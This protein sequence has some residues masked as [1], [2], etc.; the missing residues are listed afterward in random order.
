MK[1]SLFYLF[2]LICSVSLFTS[3]KDD[4]EYVHP[5]S[6]TYTFA[7]YTVTDYPWD[8][9][10]VKK[11]WPIAG[12]LHINW[13][14]KDDP[15]VNLYATLIRYLGGTI[16][17]QVLGSINLENDGNIVADYVA[18]PNV[19]MD[20]SKIMGIMLFGN[21]FPSLDEVKAGFATGGFITSPKGIATW[22]ENGGKFTVKLNIQA[23]L[24]SVTGS[25]ASSLGDI[26]NT[27]LDS[28]P[29]TIKGLLSSLLGPDI[30]NIQD[31]TISQL[32][33][34]VKNGIPMNM[35]NTDDGH[36]FI[37]LDK[38]SLNNLFTMRDI[39]KVDDWGTPEPTNDVLLLWNALSSAN[40]IPEEAESAGALLAIIG[41]YWGKTTAFDLG[42]NLVKN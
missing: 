5:L 35:V 33:G 29:T 21:D 28:D 4:D 36:T 24:E 25:D 13:D 30:N 41:G 18:T 39:G 26:I 1:K 34:W 7:D 17:P 9:K 20:P 37:Y 23:I 2:A 12:A 42:L 19:V 38:A 3:C 10:S 8:D 16:L 11:N 6:G 15:S 40:L 27:V 14:V 32:L 22:S 31:A